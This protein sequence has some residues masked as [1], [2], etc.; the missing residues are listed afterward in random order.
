M[1]AL[2]PFED[3]G[4]AEDVAGLGGGGRLDRMQA[5]GAEDAGGG[6]R[7]AYGQDG[8]VRD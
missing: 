1:G 5:N 8:E 4:V 6:G 7:S 2:D 3:A